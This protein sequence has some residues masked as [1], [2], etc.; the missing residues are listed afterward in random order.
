MGGSRAMA[1]RQASPTQSDSSRLQIWKN[2]KQISKKYKTN[3]KPIHGRI[4]GYGGLPGHS[5]LLFNFYKYETNMKQI[6]NK[7]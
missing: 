4:Q 2:I 1:V 3:M 6:W 7:R 5:T